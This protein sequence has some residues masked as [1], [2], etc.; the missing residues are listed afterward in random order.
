VTKVREQELRILIFLP[1]GCHYFEELLKHSWFHSCKGR[2][3][4]WIYLKRV[5][6]FIWLFFSQ[7]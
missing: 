1:K 7:P 3:K 6:K 5:Q 4:F 2:I